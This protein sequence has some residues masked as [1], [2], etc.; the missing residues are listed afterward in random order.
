[1][2]L[3]RIQLSNFRSI[4]E[5]SVDIFDVTALVGENNSGKSSLLRALNVFF[6]YESEEAN[7][8]A[9]RHQYTRTSQARVEL[10]FKNVPNDEKAFKDICTNE[11]LV[12]RVTFI[13]RNQKRKVEVKINGKYTTIEKSLIDSIKTHINFVFIP[14]NR[15]PEK[16]KWEEATLLRKIVDAFLEKATSNRDNFTPKFSEAVSNLERNALNKISSQ[17]KELYSLMHDFSFQIEFEKNLTFRNFLNGIR[18]LVKEKEQIYDLA[19]CGTGVQS[20]TIIALHRLLSKLRNNNVILGLE[21]PETNLHPQAQREL[22]SSIIQSTGKEDVSQIV[23]TTHSPVVI[24]QLGHEQIIHFK[25]VSDNRRSFKTATN[26]IAS[27]FFEK[28]QLEEFKYYQFHQYRNSDFFYAKY[29]IIVESKNDAEVVKLLASKLGYDAD[30]YGISI[31]SI[32][33]VNNLKYPLYLVRELKIPYLIILDKDY[34]VPYLNGDLASSRDSQ[35]FPKYRY[36]YKKKCLIDDLIPRKKDKDDLLKL[37]KR[38]FSRALDILQK[39]NIISM[40]YCLEIDLISS[41]KGA[42]LYYDLLD[43]PACK[44]SK[45]E[46]LENKKNQIKEIGNILHVTDNLLDKNLPNSYKRIKKVLREIFKCL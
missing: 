1:M 41:H 6:N 32:D 39:N 42:D 27:D 15:I 46:L 13:P 45:L 26:C 20:L 14:P 38:N 7:L 43:I 36:E 40:R 29:I 2:L 24:D 12:V 9:G 10:T 16:L 33:G 22:I 11:N 28:N 31:V 17:A 35:G 19:D 25:K 30:L 5:C 34:F 37:L 44:R 23:C 3:K 8:I 18:F 21:E 4:N